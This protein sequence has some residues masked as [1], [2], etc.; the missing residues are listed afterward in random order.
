MR[1]PQKYDNSDIPEDIPEELESS[2]EDAAKLTSSTVKTPVGKNFIE[3]L[4][5]LSRKQMLSRHAIN[6]IRDL[7]DLEDFQNELSL[8]AESAPSCTAKTFQTLKFFWNWAHE[9]YAPI[10]NEP[11]FRN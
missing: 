10:I 2:L 5:A 9:N 4:K 11:V 3:D 8:Y 7:Y 1:P 6:A